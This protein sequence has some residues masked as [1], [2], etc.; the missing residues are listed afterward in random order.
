MI[1]QRFAIMS[2]P[3][4]PLT[5]TYS[6]LVKLLTILD[7]ETETRKDG[8]E[9]VDLLCA[10]ATPER[11]S[12]PRFDLILMDLEMYAYAPVL[13]AA[14]G[15]LTQDAQACSGRLGRDAPNS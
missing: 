1:N 3:L 9:C 11:A 12:E 10:L 15:E 5:C 4:S 8:Q 13:H 6:V 2:R 14:S 7:C